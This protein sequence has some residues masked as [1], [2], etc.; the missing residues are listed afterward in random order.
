MLVGNQ[1]GDDGN[2]IDLDHALPEPSDT[3]EVRVK[4]GN[5]VCQLGHAPTDRTFS[6]TS[7]FEP[8]ATVFKPVEQPRLK[9]FGFE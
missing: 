6:V 2:R 5:A 7:T 1:L 9:R 3:E 8:Q 4:D